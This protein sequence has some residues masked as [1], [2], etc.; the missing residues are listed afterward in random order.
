MA[1]TRRI[2][3]N[4]CVIFDTLESLVP[5]DHMVRKLEEAID[6]EQIYDLVADLYSPIGRPSIDP[7]VLFKMIFINKVFGINSMRKTCEEIRVNIAYRWFLGLSIYDRVPNYSTWSQNYIRRYHDDPVFDKLFMIILEEADSQGFLDVGT[8]YGDGTH[9]KANANRN[10]TEK[11]E[12]EVEA[13]SYEEALLK[14]INEVRAEHG[15]KEFDHTDREEKVFDEETGK[16]K[17]AVRTKTVSVSTTDSDC[18]IFHKGEHER[19]AAYELQTFCDENGFVLAHDIV[20]GNVHD[21]VSFFP[22]Y[23]KVEERFG[24]R[25][26]NVC[27]DAGYKTPAICKEIIDNGKMPILPY[28]R[29]MTKKG[30]FAKYKYSYDPEMDCY[31]C[32]NG[33]RLEYSTTDRRGYSLYKSDPK[34]C[35]ACP[36]AGKCTHSKNRQKV[37]VRHVWEA[38]AEKA[39]ETRHTDLHRNIYPKRKETIE[40]VFAGSK[41]NHCLRYTRVRGLE[42]NRVNS[43]MIF[44]SHN[45]AKLARWKWKTREMN[46]VFDPNCGSFF[47]LSSHHIVKIINSG[48]VYLA[49]GQKKDKVQSK[50]HFVNNLRYPETGYLF[51]TT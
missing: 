44:A 21:S 10:R 19:C 4:D 30:F 2:H 40:R 43:T 42:K 39:E 3:K 29:P 11:K 48:I 38:Y 7:V 25:I 49:K 37:V 41:E 13:R 16:E 34:D 26:K 51:I 14:E 20:A 35:A 1:M 17:L 5:Q 32:P 47:T 50:L 27:L 12:V 28:R 15:K 9:Q 36:F 24:S 18:G 45:L 46:D 22:A 23:T 8:V 33:K 6:W 31:I